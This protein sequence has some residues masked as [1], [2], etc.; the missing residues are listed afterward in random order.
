MQIATANDIG[1][2]VEEILGYI[3]YSIKVDSAGGILCVQQVYIYTHTMGSLYT[4]VDLYFTQLLNALFGLNVVAQ[5]THLHSPYMSSLPY[6]LSAL[7]G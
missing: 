1:K 2:H 3:A 6:D 7:P 4:E 5:R